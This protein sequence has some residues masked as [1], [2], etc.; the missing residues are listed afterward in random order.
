MFLAYIHVSFSDQNLYVVYVFV[1]VVFFVLGFVVNFWHFHLLIQNHLANFNQTWHNTSLGEGDSSLFKWSSSLFL[2]NIMLII[3]VYWFEVFSQ[4]SDVANGPLVK[5]LRNYIILR[6]KYAV[7]LL[8]N[9]ED[10]PY[11]NCEDSEASMKR[12]HF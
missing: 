10:L 9:F 12:N 2:I 3:Y 1:V 5:T 8:V 7:E 11:D 4:V 6:C